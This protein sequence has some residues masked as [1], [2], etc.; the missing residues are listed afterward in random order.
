MSDFCRG[1]HSQDKRSA[2]RYFSKFTS[3]MVRLWCSSVTCAKHQS[4]SKPVINNWSCQ[5]VSSQCISH[6]SMFYLIPVANWPSDRNIH[7]Y[8]FFLTCSFPSQTQLFLSQICPSPSSCSGSY[9]A[10]QPRGAFSFPEFSKQKKSHTTL[11]E[12]LKMHSEN[13]QSAILEERRKTT[14]TQQP[15]QLSEQEISML[16]QGKCLLKMKQ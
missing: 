15:Q 1:G 8:H 11:T 7:F 12:H 16:F 13:F 3:H 2:A 10:Y 4:K 14:E 5:G 6:K 9:V